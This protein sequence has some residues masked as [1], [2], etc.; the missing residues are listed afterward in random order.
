MAPSD[1]VDRIQQEWARAYPDLDVAPVGVL[2]RVQRLAA[3]TTHRFDRNLDRHGITRSEYDVLGALARADGPI[4]ASE[5][6]ST[7][8]LS[9]ASITKLTDSLAKR[10]LLV[11]RRSERDGR[12]V[13]LELTDAGRALVDVELPRRLDDDEQVLA[14]LTPAERETL[15]GLL[16]RV[17]SSLGE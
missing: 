17:L 4:R 2:G 1:L 10:E 7:T 9:G 5:V 14:A 6:V 12:V 15:A 11:R 8:M 3:V 13:L 16:R